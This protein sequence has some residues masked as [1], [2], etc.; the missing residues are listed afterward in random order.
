MKISIS[1]HGGKGICALSSESIRILSMACEPMK[2]RKYT[3]TKIHPIFH[4]ESLP[5]NFLDFFKIQIGGYI[6]FY[7]N[8]FI[9]R[10]MPPLKSCH[11]IF[12]YF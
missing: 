4:S 3:Y 8:F 12:L 1:K 2:K 9:R 6:D 11:N 5:F 10:I 7:N